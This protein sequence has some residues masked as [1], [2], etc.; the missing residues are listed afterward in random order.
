M[1]KTCKRHVEVAKTPKVLYNLHIQNQIC[2]E[3]LV[4]F[5]PM[6]SF[7]YQLYLKYV[8]SLKS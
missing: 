7:K 1:C 5:K 3:T 4:F 6:K 2:L 8:N